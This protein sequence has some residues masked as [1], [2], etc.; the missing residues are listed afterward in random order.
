MVH[1]VFILF[2]V[3]S[4]HF[5]LSTTNDVWCLFQ[6]LLSC[7]TTIHWFLII[8]NHA[9]ADLIDISSCLFGF[10]LALVYN[11]SRRASLKWLSFSISDA[12]EFWLISIFN[13]WYGTL[14]IIQQ[15]ASDFLGA[16]NI[17]Y[18]FWLVN[19]IQ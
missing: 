12:K 4:T 2:Q 14:L 7:N 16:K 13:L 15:N 10:F 3:I 1:A 6:K 9:S 8:L 19:K 17:I 11:G 18:Q 5:V